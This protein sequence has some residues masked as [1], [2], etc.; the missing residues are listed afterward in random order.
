M[1]DRI[2]RSLGYVPQVVLTDVHNYSVRVD[3]D[4]AAARLEIDRL[5]KDTERATRHHNEIV[6]TKNATIA[7]LQ[8]AC[9]NYRKWM[10]KSVRLVSVY[11]VNDKPTQSARM[12]L[13]GVTKDGESVAVQ[14]RKLV[15]SKRNAE[16]LAAEADEIAKAFQIVNT[17]VPSLT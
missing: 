2:M 13:A 12:M 9:D 3:T 8:A 5:R 16:M 15:S 10:E 14:V 1:L 11:V 7:D 6:N 17:T 4:L